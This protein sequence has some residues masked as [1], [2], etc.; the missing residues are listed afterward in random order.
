[1]PVLR[2]S[3]NSSGR[4]EAGMMA[5]DSGCGVDGRSSPRMLKLQATLDGVGENQSV[6]SCLGCGLSHHRQFV[7]G[8]HAGKFQRLQ[9]YRA[10]WRLRPVVPN[11]VDRIARQEHQL[12]VE[13]LQGVASRRSTS[14]VGQVHGSMPS[15]RPRRSVA[16]DKR[17]KRGCDAILIIED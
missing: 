11:G 6:G 5:R 7:S 14:L 1:M 2:L 8:R 12:S 10:Q 9:R 13:W 15:L 4:P 16:L 3:M 17:G